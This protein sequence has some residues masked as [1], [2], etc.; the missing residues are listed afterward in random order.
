MF[1]DSTIARAGGREW[2]ADSLKVPPIEPGLSRGKTFIIGVTF[3]SYF[4]FTLLLSYGDMHKDNMS[5]VAG[6]MTCTYISQ[7]DNERAMWMQ[8]LADTKDKNV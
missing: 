2:T 4:S 5:R 3:D 8:Y 1:R 7:I 6:F